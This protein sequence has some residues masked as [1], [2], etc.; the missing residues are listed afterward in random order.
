MLVL[1]AQACPNPAHIIFLDRFMVIKRSDVEP[2]VRPILLLLD[3]IGQNFCSQNALFFFVSVSNQMLHP[4]K[5]G[6]I[7]ILYILTFK[8]L[9]LAFEMDT[10]L[11]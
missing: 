10:I 2:E 9:N 1:T 11:K 6:K 4:D 8:F 3:L 7:I 5:T